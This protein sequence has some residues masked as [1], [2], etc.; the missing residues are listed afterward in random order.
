MMNAYTGYIV[1]AFGVAFALIVVELI[2]L[3]R[4]NRITRDER[5]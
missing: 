3:A 2:A 4:R 1:S 5:P